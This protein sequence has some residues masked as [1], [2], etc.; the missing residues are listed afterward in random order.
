[1]CGIAYIV[2]R[3]NKPAA[4][5][6]YKRYKKQKHRGED[7]Y[8]FV[9]IGKRGKVE[10]VQRFQ[11]EH[12]AQKA[13][14]SITAPQVLLHHRYPTS[15]PNL[16]EMAHPIDVSHA[17]LQFDYLV[18][19]NGIITNADDLKDKHEKLGYKYTTLL[20]QSYKTVGGAV[21]TVAPAFNDSEAFAIELA[22]T[23]DGLQ[24]VAGAEGPIAYIAVQVEK[25]TDKAMAVYYGTNGKNPLCITEHTD[26]IALASEGGKG[27]EGHICYRLDVE[28]HAITEAPEI[29]L[30]GHDAPIVK[31]YP[32]PYQDSGY[33]EAAYTWPSKRGSTSY[34]HNNDAWEL[35]SELD[36]INADLELAKAEAEAAMAAGDIEDEDTWK[37]EI[38]T[39]LARKEKV[40]A[41]VLKK[42]LAGELD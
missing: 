26:F 39:L 42:E 4:K 36:E 18:V 14:E 16:A 7:G 21:Y 41:L 29:K 31:R 37:H 8:G 11:F 35:E 20:K 15:T 1:M 40:E 24:G 3:D 10:S 6:V 5:Q 30:V 33:S 25:K 9:A 13:L 17:E 2:R 34:R 19:H 32:Y 22:R 38:K 12:E 28:T 23:I 27:I